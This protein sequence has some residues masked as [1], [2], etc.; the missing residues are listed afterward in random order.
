M[1]CERCGGIKRNDG[2]VLCA[3]CRNPNAWRKLFPNGLPQDLRMKFEL[4]D[5]IGGE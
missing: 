2:K 3:N 1:I 5:A 4:Y